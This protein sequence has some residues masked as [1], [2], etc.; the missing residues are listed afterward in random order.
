MRKL[1]SVSLLVL[2]LSCSV[3]AGEIPNDGI[4]GEMPNDGIVSTP[5]NTTTS[6]TVE[7]Q[8]ANN[9]IVDV[10]AALLQNVLSLF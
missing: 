9:S 10:A 8:P 2:A 3:Y 4:T 7:N 5:P 1:I 6:A